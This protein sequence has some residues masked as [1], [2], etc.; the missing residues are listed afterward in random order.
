MI[1]KILK[2]FSSREKGIYGETLV[3]EYLTSKGFEIIERNYK[4]K[5][6]EIDLIVRKGDLLIFVE[7][8]SDF[9]EYELICEEKI[10]LKKKRKILSVAEQFLIKN[11]QF[12]SKIKEI[13]FDVVVVKNGRIVHYENAFTQDGG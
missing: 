7:V 13:R 8:K 6:G 11:S 9:K 3:E 10:N 12:L 4:T 5:I 2:G 1:K